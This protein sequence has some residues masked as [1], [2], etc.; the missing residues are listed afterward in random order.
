MTNNQLLTQPDLDA[1]L[2]ATDAA[3]ANSISRIYTALGN[4]LNAINIEIA[5]NPD[6][7]DQL[8]NHLIV[9]DDESRSLKETVTA[10]TQEMTVLAAFSKEVAN[11]RDDTIWELKDATDRAETAESTALSNQYINMLSNIQ[12]MFD[13][14]RKTANKILDALWDMEDGISSQTA[15]LFESLASTVQNVTEWQ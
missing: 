5:N 15:N 12:V 9:I 8:E 1:K 4:M 13:C 6:L 11:Q 7:R 2:D 10:L 14:D 3:A